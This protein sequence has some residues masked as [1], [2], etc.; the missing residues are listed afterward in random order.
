MKC[1]PFWRGEVWKFGFLWW[2]YLA[3]TGVC[4][5]LDKRL[6]HQWQQTL[7]QLTEH[8]APGAVSVVFCGIRR[9]RLFKRQRRKQ[10]LKGF[11]RI[12]GN[13]RQSG[14]AQCRADIASGTVLKSLT[15]N[16][17]QHLA[18]VAAARPSADQDYRVRFQARGM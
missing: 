7:V 14:G 3:G 10:C 18:P 4:R 8:F 17:C 9:M 6:T 2:V 5:P 12:H 16:I 11:L 15:T 1:M 13:L